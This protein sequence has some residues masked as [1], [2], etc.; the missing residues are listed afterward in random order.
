MNGDV[1]GWIRL[2]TEVGFPIVVSIYLLVRLEASIR[3]LQEIQQRLWSELDRRIIDQYHEL[4]A[5]LAKLEGRARRR[6]DR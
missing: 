4:D 1:S 6:A 2:I 3:S 5:R